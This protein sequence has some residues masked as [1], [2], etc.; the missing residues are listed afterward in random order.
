[1]SIVL[2]TAFQVYPV[3]LSVHQFAVAFYYRFFAVHSFF[4]AGLSFHF[5]DHQSSAAAPAQL[6]PMAPQTLLIT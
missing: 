5:E 1:M 4:A 6:L 2:L 3:L